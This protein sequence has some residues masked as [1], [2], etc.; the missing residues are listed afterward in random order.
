MNGIIG[1]ASL[2][3]DTDLAPEQAA[4]LELIAD[5]GRSLLAIINDILDLSKVEAG[6]IELEAIPLSP[7]GVVHGAL[8]LVR[9]EAL[10]KGVALD[11]AIAPDVPV[12]VSG[13]PTRL[14]QILLNL[15]SN[16]LKFTERGRVGVT[17]RREAQTGG[18]RLRF[19]IADTGIG[20]AAEHQHL[21]FENFSQ[22][23][24]SATR[25][26]GGSGLGL[27]ISR[28]LAEAMSGT[29]GVTSQVGA[30][31]TFWFTAELPSTAAPARSA[32]TA[33]RRADVVARRILLVDDNPLNQIV[34]QA[35]LAKEGHEVVVV[36]DGLA[37]LAVV[38]ERPFDLV[39]MDMEMPVMDGMEAARRIR[40][41]DT[42]VR[43]IPIVALTAN[44]LAEEIASCRAAGMNDHLAK[45][46]DRDRLRQVEIICRNMSRSIGF[47][48]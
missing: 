44:V 40:G 19:E 31:S 39:L 1:L 26:F 21:L 33:R 11:I 7:A 16:A 24:R 45:P 12:W 3:L 5:A 30:G 15:L 4:H 43:D 14:R 48:R 28:R 20:I 46:I 2:L 38:G 36:A 41:L 18:D 42:P 34:G 32:D 22:V 10:K 27:A 17:V 13:D 8:A 6:K 47:A 35:M 23:D 29:I 37:A 9:G 25:K